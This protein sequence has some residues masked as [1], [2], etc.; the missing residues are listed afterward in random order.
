MRN[1]NA[2]KPVALALGIVASVYGPNLADADTFGDAVEALEDGD[3]CRA[4]DLFERAADEGF[5]DSELM[6]RAE[7]E[8]E[9]EQRR[10]EQEQ[11]E[12][13]QDEAE[14][15][16]GDGVVD[17]GAEFCDDGNIRDGDGCSSRCE[18]ESRCGNGRVEQ[19][20]ECD[21]GD[22]HSG[23]G[24]SSLCQVEH[25]CGD[26]TT[27]AG[28]ECDDGNTRSFDGCSSLCQLEVQCGNGRIDQGEQCDDGNTRSSDGCSS[29]CRREVQRDDSGVFDVNEDVPWLLIAGWG[30]L[31]ILGGA[32][33]EDEETLGAILLGTCGTAFV[34]G[35]LVNLF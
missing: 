1:R 10:E 32:I 2:V 15:Y 14:S 35:L 18:R 25:Y 30:G 21:D 34:V 23:D 33:L 28:E 4:H 29:S 17:W 16:C 7:D 19:G 31:S 22:R 20:E 5:R 13:E 27:D 9:D 6:E 24:C 3:P 26:W 8:C 11:R 12:R